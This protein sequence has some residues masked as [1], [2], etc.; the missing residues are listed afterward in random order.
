MLEF[1]SSPPILTV[2][3]TRAGYSVCGLD[4][5]PDRFETVCREDGLSVKKVNFEEEPLPFA[6]DAID[7]VVF[8]EV[9]EHLRINPIFTFREI[10]RVLRPQGTLLLSTPNLISLKGWWHLAVKGHTNAALYDAFE[11]LETVGHAGHVRI[12]TPKEV[13]TFLEKMGFAVHIICHRAIG[14]RSPSKW[15]R[16]LRNAIHSFFPRLRTHFTIVATNSGHGDRAV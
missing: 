9:F 8:N 5:A 7:V 6:D 3:L 10:G 4:L 15:V 13:T 16:A 1:G 12:Y 14:W 11:E 2:A